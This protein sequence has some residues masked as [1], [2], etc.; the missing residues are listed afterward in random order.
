MKT[1]D[2]TDKKYY[3]WHKRLFK[4]MFNNRLFEADCKKY[5]ESLASHSITELAGKLVLVDYNK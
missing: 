5:D 2:P 4:Q 1:P 3:Y